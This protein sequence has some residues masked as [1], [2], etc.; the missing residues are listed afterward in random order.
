MSRI[1][2]LLLIFVFIY[3][4][5][6]I[7]DAVIFNNDIKESRE[8]VA[9]KKT[10]KRKPEIIKNELMVDTFDKKNVNALKGNVNP[11][12]FK[13]EDNTQSC[14]I[15]YTKE[16]RMGDKGSSLKV[17][18]DV[19]SPNQAFNGVYIEL[20]DSDIS[21]FNNIVFYVKGDPDKGFTSVFKV[22][23]KNN[24]DQTGYA[25]VRGVTDEWQKIVISLD[26]FRGLSDFTSMKEFT[27]VFADTDVT[28]KEGIIYFE[29]LYFSK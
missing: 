9:K 25:Y 2:L 28:Q 11:W 14:K 20:K 8:V 6:P 7:N 29:D 18:Y 10:E 23:L 21:S 24:V 15:R 17:M 27:I 1:P 4:C 16:V 3:S 19:D 5:T 22:E 12:D 26:D 13:P